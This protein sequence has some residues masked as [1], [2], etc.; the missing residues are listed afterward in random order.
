M[1]RQNWMNC[2]LSLHK[3][4]IRLKSLS[5]IWLIYIRTSKG[6]KLGTKGSKVLSSWPTHIVKWFPQETLSGSKGTRHLLTQYLKR[7][8]RTIRLYRK[9]WQRQGVV[10]ATF[11]L[12]TMRNLPA[13]GHLHQTYQRKIQESPRVIRNLGWSILQLNNQIARAKSRQNLRR[14]IE[15]MNSTPRNHN[16][17]NHHFVQ[18]VKQ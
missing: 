6:S 16:K 1:T 11:R 18:E 8:S 4:E 7:K 2:W 14:M 17:Q 15:M 9:Q 3:K 13:K 12:K 5:T 10:W